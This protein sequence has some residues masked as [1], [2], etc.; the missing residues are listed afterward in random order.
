MPSSLLKKGDKSPSKSD[1]SENNLQN[2]FEKFV[3]K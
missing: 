3:N 2:L 1:I